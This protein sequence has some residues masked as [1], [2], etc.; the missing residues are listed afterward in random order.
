MDPVTE[1]HIDPTG[2]KNLLITVMIFLMA[3]MFCICYDTFKATNLAETTKTIDYHVENKNMKE[4]I[5]KEYNVCE[6]CVMNMIYRN[7]DDR[8]RACGRH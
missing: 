2:E 6:G 4:F 8:C 7:I 3:M 1:S 5:S